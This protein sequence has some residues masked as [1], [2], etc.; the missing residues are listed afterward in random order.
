[1]MEQPISERSQDQSEE[2][3]RREV[4]VLKSRLEEKELQLLH[5]S[6]TLEERKKELWCHNRISLLLDDVQSTPGELFEKVA[7]IIPQAFQYADH[8]AA[9][10]H[11]RGVNYYSPDYR[12]SDISL[13]VDIQIRTNPPGYIRVYY[14]LNGSGQTAPVFLH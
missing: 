9:V 2:R 11:V 8:A 7:A 6:K 12:E 1:M 14:H 4:S 5:L 3:L 10:V 13:S